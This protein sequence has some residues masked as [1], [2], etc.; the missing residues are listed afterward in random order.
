M[1]WNPEKKPDSGLLAVQ[2][3]TCVVSWTVV[4][5]LIGGGIS[6]AGL[7][8]SFVSATALVA[9]SWALV[10]MELSCDCD[11]TSRLFRRRQADTR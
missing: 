11:A 4:V 9:V 8:G 10:K 5:F 3:C 6:G 7:I 1:A 2:W